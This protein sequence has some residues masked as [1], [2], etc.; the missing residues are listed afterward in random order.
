MARPTTARQFR[1]AG[2]EIA[3]IRSVG[4]NVPFTIGDD[5]RERIMYHADGR[6]HIAMIVLIAALVLPVVGTIGLTAAIQRRIL[7][8]APLDLRIGPVHILAN[9]SA[10]KPVPACPSRSLIPNDPQS[11]AACSQQFYVLLVLIQTGAPDDK[12]WILQLL[13]LPIEREIQ[14]S[15]LNRSR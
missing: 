12:P 7:A 9:V 14:A 4:L 10:P 5:I 15:E 6:M 3:W 8:P 13:N 2:T 11:F 1:S